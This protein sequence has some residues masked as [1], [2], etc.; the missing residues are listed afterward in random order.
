L[1]CWLRRPATDRHATP[2]VADQGIA[3]GAG[4]IHAAE[5]RGVH[6][7]GS[8]DSGGTEA[9]RISNSRG[10]MNSGPMTICIIGSGISGLSAAYF[11]SKYQNVRI[12]VYEGS[13]FFGGRANVTEDGEHCPRV[14]LSD[15]A[16]LFSILRG[17]ENDD[18]S[19]IYDTLEAVHRYCHIEGRGWAE[20]SHLYVAL[21]RELSLLDRFKVVKG[22]HTSPLV[23]AQVPGT[24]TNRYGSMRNFSPLSL[25]RVITNL[26]RS[27]IAFALGGPTDECLISPWV[28]YLEK[29]GVVFRKSHRVDAVT[30]LPHGVSVH[31]PAGSARFDAAVVTAFVPDLADLL[32]ASGI[33]HRI[34]V[35]SQTHC[36]CLTLT[37]DPREKILATRQLAL[38]SR[39]GI[40]VVVQPNHGRCVVLCTRPLS[41]D[42][43]YVVSRIREFLGLEHEIPVI[44][45]RD[46]QQPEEAIYAADY[47]KPDA[48]LRQRA[49]HLYFAGSY[50]KNSYPVDSGEGAARSAFAAVQKIERDFRLISRPAGSAA[51]CSPPESVARPHVTR[52]APQREPA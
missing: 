12:T 26:R 23:A 43:G 39:A 27:T 33:D 14:F 7:S 42:V 11:L 6:M 17:V 22:R 50:I 49:P 48:I 2:G 36:K 37:L 35:L 34:K 15:Y 38:Y 19:S 32:T 1:V 5:Q 52:T 18:G 40:N 4:A 9:E 8:P 3:S 16:C 46:N 24:N 21:A 29:A 31:S 44:K 20:I 47:L 13:R 30:P 45:V 10:P 41:T 25:L 51:G 28:R